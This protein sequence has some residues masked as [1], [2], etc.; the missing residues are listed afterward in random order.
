MAPDVKAPSNSQNIKNLNLEERFFGPAVDV[1]KDQFFGK[2][3]RDNNIDVNPTKKKKLSNT[4]SVGCDNTVPLAL[5]RIIT[6]E[7]LLYD[8]EQQT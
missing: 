1:Y 6:L 4:R 3:S 8:V 5:P 7:A 2:R